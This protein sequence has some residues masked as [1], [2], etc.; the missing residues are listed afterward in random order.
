MFDL[1]AAIAMFGRWY[2]WNKFMNDRFKQV[3]FTGSVLDLT[4]SWVLICSWFRLP[5][6]KC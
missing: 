3:M 4:C 1:K 2:T 6:R 5:M